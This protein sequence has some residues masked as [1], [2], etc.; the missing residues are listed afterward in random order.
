MAELGSTADPTAL[1]PGRP[2]DVEVAARTLRTRGDAAERAALG[3]RAID[4]GS[5][6]GPAAQAFHDRFSYEPNRWFDA[7]DAL[8]RAADL[9]T[10]HASTLRWAQDQAAEAIARW[11]ATEAEL[12]R[13]ATAESAAVKHALA[14]GEPVPVFVGP[15]AAAY[16]DAR[17]ILDRARA[18]LASAG[19]A[20]A[21]FVA[22]ETDTAPQRSSW[23][24]TLADGAQAVGSGITTGLAS[25]GNAMIHHPEDVAALIGGAALTTISAGGDAVGVALDATGVGAVAGVPLNVVSTAGVV[26]GTTM[27]AAAAGDLGSHAAGE[28]RVTAPE[29][30]PRPTRTDRLKEHLTDRD[31]DAARRELGGEVVKTKGSGQPWD[32]VDEVRNAQRGLVNQI[33]RLERSL[34]DSRLDPAERPAIEAELSE[35]SKLLDH[36]EQWV[37]R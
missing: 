1:V 5:W 28:D 10:D 13:T 3:L 16:D 19:D 29:E 22:A 12:A 36:S 2:A 26:T 32:H 23:L 21:G 14:H 7:A 27:M 9:L 25:V 17:A 30:P 18:Q 6:T 35:A 31:L 8:H 33:N 4:T 11:S 34:G 15:G 37:P 20:V 24:H